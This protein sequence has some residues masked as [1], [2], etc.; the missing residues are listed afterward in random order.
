MEGDS[1]LSDHE[2]S[3]H[4]LEITRLIEECEYTEDEYDDD[5]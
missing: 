2:T 5:Y 3:E 1:H 4:D